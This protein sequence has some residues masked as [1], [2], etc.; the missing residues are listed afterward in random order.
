MLIILGSERVR[1]AVVCNITVF[2]AVLQS[3]RMFIFPR[4]NSCHERTN[5]LIDTKTNKVRISL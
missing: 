3:C 4:D 2:P 5:S 1:L